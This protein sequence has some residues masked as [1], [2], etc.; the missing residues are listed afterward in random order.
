[1]GEYYGGWECEGGSLTG[2]AVDDGLLDAGY[3]SVITRCIIC[4]PRKHLLVAIPFK[5][6]T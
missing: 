3:G 4:N 6:Y 2:L 1:V 5:P